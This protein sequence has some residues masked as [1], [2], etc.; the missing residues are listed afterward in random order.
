MG[1][2]VARKAYPDGT[3]SL[4]EL[5]SLSL[6]YKDDLMVAIVIIL[7]LDWMGFKVLVW[8]ILLF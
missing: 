6:L 8:V 4:V 1:K 7:S 3:Y 2:K 5:L